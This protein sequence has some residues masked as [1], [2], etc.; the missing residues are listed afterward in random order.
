MARKAIRGH[1]VTKKVLSLCSL[2]ERLGIP[3]ATEVVERC[4][5]LAQE[6]E[7]RAAIVVF[8]RLVGSCSETWLA[9]LSPKMPVNNARPGPRP[10]LI[11]YKWEFRHSAL[12]ELRQETREMSLSGECR[13]NLW[14]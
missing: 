13:T 8:Y 7:R 5:W 11:G 6:K 10:C 4:T 3:I 14:A 1:G 9:L 2:G 12:T